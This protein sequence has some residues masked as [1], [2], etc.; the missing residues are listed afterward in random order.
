MIGAPEIYIAI[1]VIA[2]AII[3]IFIVYIRKKPRKQPS[4]LA[5]FA[6]LLVIVGIV[7]GDDR[8]IGYSLIGAGMI[9]A[10][11]DIIKNKLI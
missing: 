9:L 8:L 10:I 3:A 5:M 7:F 2:L 6:I 1:A 4:K 11:F